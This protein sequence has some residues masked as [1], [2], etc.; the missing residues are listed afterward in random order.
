MYYHALQ[1]KHSTVN[2]RTIRIYIIKYKFILFENMFTLLKKPK[3]IKKI[4]MERTITLLT[5]YK[6]LFPHSF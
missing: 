6:I 5:L 2:S 4:N 3:V 1:D